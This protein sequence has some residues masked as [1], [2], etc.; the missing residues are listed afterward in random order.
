VRRALSSYGRSKWEGEKEDQG[1][2]CA[3]ADHSHVLGLCGTRHQF[4][5]DMNRL[6]RERDE[7]RVV[8]DQYGAPTSAPSIAEA[9]WLSWRAARQPPKSSKYKRAW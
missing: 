8:A 2:R 9:S 6:A 1:L 5:S 7:L 3:A 4:F